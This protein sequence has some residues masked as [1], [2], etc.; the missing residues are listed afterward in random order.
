MRRML[1]VL[2]ILAVC[3]LCPGCVPFISKDPGKC[4]VSPDGKWLAYLLE[5][6]LYVTCPPEAAE[7][8]KTA[9]VRYCS[10]DRPDKVRSVNV[11][12]WRG[13][14][15]WETSLSAGI[16]LA[17]A[18]SS[19]H[20]AV[21]GPTSISV[22]YLKTKKRWKVYAGEELIAS[23]KW[24]S[25]VEI[26]Y[27]SLARA[28]GDGSRV[29]GAWTFWRQRIDEPMERRT[30]IYRD[31]EEEEYHSW[32]PAPRSVKRGEYW[33]PDGRLVLLP[34][35]NGTMLLDVESSEVRPVG[36]AGCVLSESDA[37][38][39]RADS[40]VVLW[41]GRENR[42]G[43]KRRA[44]LV[45]VVSNEEKDI[46]QSFYSHRAVGL[47]WVQLDP[48]WTPDGKYVVGNAEDD[49]G[50]LIQPDP[51]EVVFVGKAVAKGD[52]KRAAKLER[53]G[54]QGARVERQPVPGMLTA[55]VDGECVV[56]YDG[57]VLVELGQRGYGWIIL[58]DGKRAATLTS[59]GK[60]VI[61]DIELH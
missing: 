56:A 44:F 12:G 28:A 36:P 10:L 43:G 17:F 29:R 25:N 61:R 40:A 27:L 57:E 9:Y 58:P 1:V 20:V 37:A 48:L 55:R 2:V 46:T 47:S 13:L 33:S 6:G 26:G 60:I 49:G 22:I 38:S 14:R 59:N 41:T 31:A 7:L 8:S 30:V 52:A 42:I 54:K 19:E 39:W 51:W 16:G 3:G 35:R 34:A 24:L 53:H 50:F 15:Q 32:P 4:H 11:A 23:V 21:R 5:E 45:N 18:P